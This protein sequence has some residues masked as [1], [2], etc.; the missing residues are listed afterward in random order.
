[1]EINQQNPIHPF[2]DLEFEFTESMGFSL[3]R[4]LLENDPRLLVKSDGKTGQADNIKWQPVKMSPMVGNGPYEDHKYCMYQYERGVRTT[5]PL[6]L[7]AVQCNPPLVD[8]CSKEE[9]ARC[10]CRPTS[11]EPVDLTVNGFQLRGKQDRIAF[12]PFENGCLDK[13]PAGS[14]SPF[15]P[16]QS[17]SVDDDRS[18][19]SYQKITSMDTGKFRICITHADMIFDIGYI[20]VRPSCE[21]PLVMVDGTCVVHC[22][23]VTVPV[24]GNCKRDPIVKQ[25]W[26][27]RAVMSAVKIGPEVAKRGIAEMKSDEPERRYFI[28]RFRY[29]LA[30]LL[31]CDPNR[32]VVGSL[33]GP[34]LPT[35]DTAVADEDQALAVTS[36]AVGADPVLLNPDEVIDLRVTVSTVFL[37]VDNEGA[38]TPS[39]ERSPMALVSLL[40]KLQADQSSQMYANNFFKYIDRDFVPDAVLVRVCHDGTYRIFCPYTKPS[41]DMIGAGLIWLGGSVAVM[42]IISTCCY[43]CWRADHFDSESMLERD[44]KKQRPETRREFAQSWL[45]GRFCDEHWQ[46]LRDKHRPQSLA[47]KN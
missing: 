29:D 1:M 39:R 30:R 23:K 38:E 9:L 15:S 11:D 24:A 46:A 4:T 20:V 44:P 45:E 2:E 16:P 47:I 43:G 21:A 13:L 36:G 41:V 33:A 17:V 22:T 42:V 34:P 18:V 25:P 27:D 40:Q 10:G 32:I 37:P 7:A 12:R 8:P 5:T 26:D 28:Y 35:N 6:C 31:D 14:K 3:P 19:N